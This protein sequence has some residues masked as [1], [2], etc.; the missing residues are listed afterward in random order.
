MK[1]FIKNIIVSVSVITLI[2]ASFTACN[3]ENSPGSSTADNKPKETTAVATTA[4]PVN[5][6]LQPPEF[7]CESGFYDSSFSLT[8]SSESDNTKIYYTTDGSI[9]TSESNLY[10]DPIQITDRSSEPNVLS[11]IGG[12]TPDKNSEFIPSSPV[13]KGTVIRAVAVDDDNTSSIVSTNTY[14]VGLSQQNDYNNSVIIS[15]STDRNNFFDY[16]NGIYVLGAAY[17][18]WSQSVNVNSY[19]TWEMEGNYTQRGRE[20][21]RPVHMELIEP[22]GKS[23]FEQDLG[24]RIMG[25][26]TRSYNQKSLRLYARDEYGKKRIEY[27]LIPDLQKKGDPETEVD[28][29]KTF[30]LR[31]GGNDCDYTKIRDPLIQKLLSDRDIATVGS[32]PAVVFLDGEYWGLYSIQEDY[33]DNY[34]QYHYGIDNNDVVMIKCGDLEEGTEEDISLYNDYNIFVNNKDLS[35]KSDYEDFCKMVDIQNF[36]DYY[37][38]LI[39]TANE[40]CIINFDNNWRLWRSRTVTDKDYHDGKWRFMLYDTEFS[41]GLYKGGK[42]SGDNS[43]TAAMQSSLFRFLTKSDD[44]KKQFALTFMDMTNLNFNPE[45]SLPVLDSL[46]D[47]YRSNATN[48]FT[49]FGPSWL[50]DSS[51]EQTE[52]YDENV[53]QI[54]DFLSKRYSYAPKMLK[55]AFSLKGEAVELTVNVNNADAGTVKINTITPDFSSGK[56]TGLYFTDYPVTLT[57]QCADGY[58]FKEWKGKEVNSSDPTITVKFSEAVTISADFTKKS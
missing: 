24:I 46:V 1:K 16:N 22:D 44:F 51:I 32:R 9:P 29:Y 57:A 23:V 25:K 20:W 53:N 54:R 5:N 41:L 35:K 28:K 55:N 30:L 17:D 4:M 31:N 27:S 39:Y 14:F 48:T 26:A 3:N 19:D 45:N 6:E 21:E 33:S 11:A 43:L 56:W 50:F 8:L 52:Y 13:Q 12:I 34:I 47:E 49:R 38:T 15:L 58:S 18:S 42:N 7:S 40:D 37:C 2:S 10:S 36:I